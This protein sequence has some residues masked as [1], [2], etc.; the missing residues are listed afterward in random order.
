MKYVYIV[1]FY[2][3]DTDGV[4]ACVDVKSAKE[5]IE[6]YAEQYAGEFEVRE[7]NGGVELYNEYGVVAEAICERVPFYKNNA[8]S[9]DN[10][11]SCFN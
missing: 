11:L 6:Q 5:V 7:I 9:I 8:T 4:C 3:P 1:S 2:G 10:V